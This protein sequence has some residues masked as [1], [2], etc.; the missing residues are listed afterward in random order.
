MLN[1]G[2]GKDIF[3]KFQTHNS[4]CFVACADFILSTCFCHN[5]PLKNIVKNS[6]LTFSL[7][8]LNSNK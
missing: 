2:S 1:G 7:F 3:F 8:N 6:G 5:L 4:V